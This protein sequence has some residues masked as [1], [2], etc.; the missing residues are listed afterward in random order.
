MPLTASA[1]AKTGPRDEWT[2]GPM[3]DS[4]SPT[5]KAALFDELVAGNPDVVWVV[6][7]DWETMDFVSPAYEEV[8]GRS[9][10]ALLED[11]RDFLAGVHP[12]DRAEV[13]AEME[14]LSRG[15]PAEVEFRVNESEDYGRWVWVKGRP[16]TDGEGDV[17]RIAGFTRD[18]TGRKVHQRR[19]AS[20]NA[21]AAD[22]MHADSLE[23]AA[24]IAVDIARDVID[25]PLTAVWH[26]DEEDH[27]LVPLAASEASRELS[28]SG[29]ETDAVGPLPAGSAEMAAFE[30]GE[31]TVFEDYASVED[32]AHPDTPLGTLL[33]APL[34][35]YGLLCVGS[36][37][38]ASFDTGEVTLV[39][40]LASN[41]AANVGRIQRRTEL[42]DQNE[43]LEQFTRV[44]SHDLQNPLS[45]AR[46]RLEL[47]RQ[48]NDSSNLERTAAALDRMESMVDDTLALARSGEQ[49]D[50]REPVDLESVAEDSWAQVAT[51]DADLAVADGLAVSADRS[52]LR[53]VFENLFR[54]AVQHGGPA[55][56]VTVGRLADGAGFYVA[57]TGGG[58]PD[59]SGRL[60]ESG[61]TTADEGT[62]LGLSIVQSI[63]EAHGWTV[64]AT[65]GEEGGARV[66]VQ[67]VDL[68]DGT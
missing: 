17:A 68:T 20:L 52:R 28:G 13:R 26:Y 30:S 2:N 16:I 56:T 5:E 42:A 6:S 43:R 12:E 31:T 47:A 49:I 4:L 64:T 10:E 57:D 65:A 60:F 38:A 14:R 45:V 22:L 54:N 7:P 58:F 55:V 34:D 29:T 36:E 44:I 67:G 61:Y 46:G 11:A 23:A 27:E 51:R 21:A 33:C 62:G 8:W 48:E 41:V 24:D 32:R 15:S 3:A 39:E 63:V 66:E 25:L 9:A 1:R 35:E 18:V 50:Q 40:I 59:D 37:S 19:L 53:E